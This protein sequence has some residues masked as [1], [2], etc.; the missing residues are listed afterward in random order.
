MIELQKED[1]VPQKEGQALTDVSQKL[2]GEV[3]GDENDSK[4]STLKSGG[5][6]GYDCTSEC[7]TGGGCCTCYGILDCL[8]LGTSGQCKAGTIGCG[9]DGCM[10]DWKLMP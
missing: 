3:S 7:G 10:C 2:D 4:E 5:G 8:L 9:G 1:Q 6:L